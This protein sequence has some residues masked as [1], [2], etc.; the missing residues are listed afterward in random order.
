[1]YIVD[2]SI[3]RPV[4]IL[5]GCLALVI[6]GLLAY[7]TLPVS[8]LPDIS[9]PVVSVQT[10][11]GLKVRTFPY[12]LKA[13]S[14]Q[15]RKLKILTYPPAPVFSN[16]A[17]LPMFMIHTVWFVSGRFSTIKKRAAGM[18]TRSC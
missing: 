1:M 6:F 9:V 7:F 12:A 2:L 17:S 8:L 11:Y 5:M 16:S 4:T 13:N 10:I 3:K 18:K 15:L 14:P